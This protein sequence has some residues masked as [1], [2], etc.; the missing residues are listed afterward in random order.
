MGVGFPER[1]LWQEEAEHD[2]EFLE[3]W[4]EE[5]YFGEDDD[6]EEYLEDE[7]EEDEDIE[8]D[9]EE[10]T[11]PSATVVRE[12]PRIGRNDS[13]PCGSGKK[14]KKCCMKKQNGGDLLD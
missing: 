6:D 9:D 3:M 11:P 4:R 10:P 5:H 2:D 1:D 12:E 8:D 14:Y 7:W 13:C